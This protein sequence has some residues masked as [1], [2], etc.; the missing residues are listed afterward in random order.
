MC[1]RGTFPVLTKTGVGILF[2]S[3]DERV[4]GATTPRS[5]SCRYAA[6]VLLVL[7]FLFVCSP[8]SHAVDVVFDGVLFERP[9][10]WE[11]YPSHVFISGTHHIWYCGTSDTFPGIDGIFH[12]CKDG[13]L[14]PGGWSSSSAPTGLRVE[15]RRH[16]R[17]FSHDA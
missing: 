10:A 8:P 6:L 15:L 2:Q 12:V 11:V 14:G 13:D 16:G 4:R 3:E 1:E 9:N 7:C 17:R 5:R